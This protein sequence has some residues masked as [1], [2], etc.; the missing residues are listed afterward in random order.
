VVLLVL[1]LYYS[2]QLSQQPGLQPSRQQ[3]QRAVSISAPGQ[4]LPLQPV[5]QHQ[6]VYPA[7][8]EVTTLADP[9]PLEVD[10]FLFLYITCT[11]FRYRN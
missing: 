4:Q 8:I 7:D 1:L 5:C 3:Q 10:D 11:L 6:P 9:D 2:R